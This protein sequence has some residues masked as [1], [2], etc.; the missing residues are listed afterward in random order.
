MTAA[1]AL[2]VGSDPMTEEPAA[3]EVTKLNT[4]LTASELV[5]VAGDAID[6]LGRAVGVRTNPSLGGVTICCEPLVL[7]K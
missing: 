5:V 7:E 6:E 3:A 1:L 2:V 4:D